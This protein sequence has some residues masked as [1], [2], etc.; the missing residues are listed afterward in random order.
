MEPP[1][2][3]DYKVRVYGDTVIETT[4]ATNPQGEPTTVT[5]VWVKQNGQWKAASVHVSPRTA[6]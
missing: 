4:S 5:A 6:K 2:P 1:L 3:A